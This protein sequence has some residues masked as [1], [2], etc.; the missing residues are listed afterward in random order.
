MKKQVQKRGVNS[1]RAHQ[2]ESENVGM[3]MKNT[4][5]TQDQEETVN[6]G[7]R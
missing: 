1:E 6:Q 5:N 2:S 3:M 7:W 4:F